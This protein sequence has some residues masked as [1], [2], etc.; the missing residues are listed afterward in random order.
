MLHD[1]PH[2]VTPFPSDDTLPI[3][4]AA[5][6]F[7][8]VHGHLDAKFDE[9]ECKFDPSHFKSSLEY[10]DPLPSCSP[11]INH[12]STKPLLDAYVEAG[13]TQMQVS[14]KNSTASLVAD[15][16]QQYYPN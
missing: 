16:I 4:E 7:A 14:H 15:S 13:F 6:A 5:E 12:P 8:N 10:S 11:V 2:L 3:L 1:V 9:H